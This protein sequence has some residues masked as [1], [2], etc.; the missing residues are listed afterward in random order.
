MLPLRV[1]GRTIGACLLGRRDPDDFYSAEELPLFRSIA[2]QIALALYNIEQ[3][4]RL[5]A[6]HHANIQRYEQE[7]AALARELHDDVLNRMVLI[8]M[9]VEN[10]E[11]PESLSR[12]YQK[13]IDHVRGL[14]NG[15]RPP[16]IEY[17]LAFALRSLMDE[18]SEQAPMATITLEGPTEENTL[19]RLPRDVETHLFRIVQEACRNAL[20][21]GSPDCHIHV[22]IRYVHGQVEIT[23]RDDGPGFAANGLLDLNYLL[24][25]KHFGLAIMYERAQII[26]AQLQIRSTPGQGT[27]VNVSWGNPSLLTSGA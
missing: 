8:S 9:S 17:G 5:R 23:I 19:Q 15:L 4:R 3:T 26:G 12:E 14:I 24:L 16:L 13:V 27:E 18:L 10:S 20:R 11:L 7:Q 25:N 6:F 21:Y 22:T 1:A 2:D